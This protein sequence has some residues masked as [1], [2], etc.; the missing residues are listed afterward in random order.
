M[1]LCLRNKSNRLLHEQCLPRY[2]KVDFHLTNSYFLKG[3]TTAQLSSLETERI[4]ELEMELK[5]PEA[6]NEAKRETMIFGIM[7]LSLQVALI[8][9]FGAYTNYPE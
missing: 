9:I 8:V 6:L 4:K 3:L 5:S 2:F 1:K 7:I